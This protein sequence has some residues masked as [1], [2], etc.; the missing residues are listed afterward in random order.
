MVSEKLPQRLDLGL[1]VGAFERIEVAKLFQRIEP[2]G[3]KLESACDPPLPVW[4]S[5]MRLALS[6]VASFS[7]GC[8]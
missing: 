1:G 7:R 8:E 2:F 3:L 4:R 6:L 5:M